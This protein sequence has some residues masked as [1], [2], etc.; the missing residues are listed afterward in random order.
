MLW[1]LS[2]GSGTAGRHRP[3]IQAG[4]GLPHPRNHTGLRKQACSAILGGAVRLGWVPD[5]GVFQTVGAN[6]LAMGGEAALGM[7]CLRMAA[8]RMAPRMAGPRMAA[9][10]MAVPSIARSHGVLTPPIIQDFDGSQPP[11]NATAKPTLACNL[12]VCTSCSRRCACNAAVCAV[13]TSR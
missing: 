5:T 11:P 7:A 13:T 4:A 3:N 1:L 12:R 8:L 6:L 9:P 10:R 2:S